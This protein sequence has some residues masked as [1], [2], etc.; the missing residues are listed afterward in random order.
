[1]VAP[2]RL[3]YA[4]IGSETAEIWGKVSRYPSGTFCWVE[5]ATTDVGA[6]KDF[7]V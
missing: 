3:G 5:L 6:A 1:M 7:Y 4:D 2:R